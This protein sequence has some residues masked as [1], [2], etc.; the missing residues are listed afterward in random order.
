MDW[1]FRS[2]GYGPIE[3]DW[4][5]MKS[6]IERH[7]ENEIYSYSLCREKSDFFPRPG[8]PSSAQ[9]TTPLPVEKKCG[10][11]TSSTRP[12]CFVQNSQTSALQLNRRHGDELVND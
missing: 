8:I 7:L 3:I 1:Y 6:K 10:L 4:H 9:G 5:Y 11:L 12:N 2:D